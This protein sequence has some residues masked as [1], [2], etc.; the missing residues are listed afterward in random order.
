MKDI[1]RQIQLYKTTE[2]DIVSLNG[3]TIVTAQKLTASHESVIDS[4]DIMIN[5]S[6]K[7]AAKDAA[8]N[9]F[10]GLTFGQRLNSQHGKAEGNK[11]KIPHLERSRLKM[12]D[13]RPKTGGS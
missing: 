5:L 1:E 6:G 9:S 3:H 10:G 7:L 4:S 8:Y 12:C 11:R 13:T 2:N